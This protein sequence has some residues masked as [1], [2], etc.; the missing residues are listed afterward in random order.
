ML[1]RDKKK[2]KTNRN[3]IKIHNTTS[4]TSQ[5]TKILDQTSHPFTNTIINSER[6]FKKKRKRRFHKGIKKKQEKSKLKTNVYNLS[7][8]PLT[9]DQLDLFNRGLGFSI[10]SSKPDCFWLDA[11]TN[12]FF[13]RL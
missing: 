12:D 11:D 2:T 10:T 9:E 1:S 13:C 4:N 3:N 7:N 8:V 5:P 6:K